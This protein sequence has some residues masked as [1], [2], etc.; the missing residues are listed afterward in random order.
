MN[1]HARPDVSIRA[2][3][4]ST[5]KV[6][7]GGRIWN[8]MLRWTEKYCVFVQI[9]G[10]DGSVG[11]GE[12]WC[13]DERPDT[14]LAY[15]KTE[16]CPRFGGRSLGEARAIF[17]HLRSRATLT[18]RHGLLESALAGLDIALWDMAAKQAGL[19]LW[20]LL[21]PQGPG[22]APL[23]C[24]G[25]I[26][27]RDKSLQDLAD[28]MAGLAAQGFSCL[29]MKIGGASEQ[30]DIA[31]VEAVLKAVGPEVRLVVDS[32]YSYDPRTAL[33]IYRRFDPARIEA[34]QSPL[35]QADLKGMQW[36]VAQGVPV[37]GIEAEYRTEL[38]SAMI[39]MNACSCTRAGF[40]KRARRNRS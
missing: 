27:G 11:L 17:A 19:P 6:D 12:C 29:K 9:H 22:S 16:I 31:R 2:I 10:S 28:E 40:W 30:E 13:L 24:S 4:V 38:H 8:P 23:Y 26:Y 35:P 18:A 7:L 37:M 25:G 3:E 15:L 32:V 39:E 1:I 5:V 33:R 36:L 34:F 20:K 21:D 14:L